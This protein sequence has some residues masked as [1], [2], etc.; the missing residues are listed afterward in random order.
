MTESA[1]DEPRRIGILEAYCAELQRLATTL[2]DLLEVAQR[3]TDLSVGADL[4]PVLA[5]ETTIARLHGRLAA[6]RPQPATP[7]ADPA[8]IT[9]PAQEERTI[10]ELCRSAVDATVAEMLNSRGDGWSA[11]L[12]A[13]LTAVTGDETGQHSEDGELGRLSPEP[14]V[15]APDRTL[16]ALLAYVGR[17]ATLHGTAGTMPITGVFTMLSSARKTGC[18]HLRRTDE[19]L[20]FVFVNGSVVATA[21]TLSAPDQLLGEILVT[22]GALSADRRQ[23]LVELA[24]TRQRPLG[25]VA[26]DEGDVSVQQLTAALNDQVQA[27]FDRAFQDPAIAY[28][29]VPTEAHDLDGRIRVSARELLFEGAL[30]ADRNRRSCAR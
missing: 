16:P 19:H 5:L 22:C 17:W 11:D 14:E 1:P 30:R 7:A 20:R 28:A 24:R 2:C 27:R 4:A 9:D 21:T 8:P 25:A 26:V 13:L 23:E 10:V 3:R 6:A 29:F 15:V 12:H 18:L